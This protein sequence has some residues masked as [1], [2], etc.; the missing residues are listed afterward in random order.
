[1]NTVITSSTAYQRMRAKSFA[2][3]ANRQ[4]GEVEARYSSQKQDHGANQNAL[5]A[6]G[7]TGILSALTDAE[8]QSRKRALS[9]ITGFG[10]KAFGIYDRNI[11]EAQ[12]DAEFL[13]N[14][15]A[16]HFEIDE[17][18]LKLLGG[19]FGKIDKNEIRLP[20]ET[21]VFYLNYRRK[22]K[23]TGYS[24]FVIL[25][26]HHY[27]KKITIY[28]LNG[29]LVEVKS[30]KYLDDVLAVLVA[31]DTQIVG[32]SCVIQDLKLTPR[33][34]DVWK[35][36]FKVLR[37]KTAKKIIEGAHCIN[38]G[39]KAVALHYRRGCWV[40][41]GEKVFWRRAT[42]VGNIENGVVDKVYK[43]GRN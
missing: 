37:L 26:Q 30:S 29:T 4:Y 22:N 17:N 19:I 35:R 41:R 23:I 10:F 15:N 38:T 28:E 1:M 39:R 11:T 25:K 5:A 3:I 14:L 6:M 8:Y 34:P 16:H 32:Q 36:T 12:R 31:M 40:H 24:P 18:Y 43:V 2:A 13:L 7:L 42:I 27:T 9:E 20:Y 33:K 21:C